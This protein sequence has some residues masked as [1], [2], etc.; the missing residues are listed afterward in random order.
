MTN[1]VRFDEKD[2]IIYLYF[3]GDQ[4]YDTVTAMWP[5][6]EKAANT[7]HGAH[8][9]VLVLGNTIEMQHQDSGSRKSGA[10]IIK[11]IQITK[12][13]LVIT[14]PFLRMVSQLIAKGTGLESKVKHFSKEEDA[15]AWLREKI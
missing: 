11:K 2:G 14:S 8:R 4:T 1:E 6:M 15:V 9:P 13:A 10:E 12:Y 7:L 3:R 5:A